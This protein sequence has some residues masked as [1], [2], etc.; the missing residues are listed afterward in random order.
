MRHETAE[1][2]GYSVV[3]YFRKRTNKK[4]RKDKYHEN[5]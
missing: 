1:S 4:R 2:D 5:L 3:Y